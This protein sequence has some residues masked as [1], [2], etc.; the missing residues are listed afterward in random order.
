MRQIETNGKWLSIF[1]SLGIPVDGHG[2]HEICPL[3]KRK[4][5]RYDD[6]EGEGTWIC[7]CDAGSS[8]GW[9]LIIKYFEL[10]EGREG[11][12]AALKMVSEAESKSGGFTKKPP[13]EKKLATPADLNR[14]FAEANKQREGDVVDLYLFNRGIEKRP[15][16]NLWHS[17]ECWNSDT[18]RKEHAMMSVWTMPD[19][20]A[21][22]AERTYLTADGN[23]LDTVP[24]KLVKKMTSSLIHN[25]TGG[26]VRLFDLGESKTLGLAEGIETTLAATQHFNIPFWATWTADRL[27]GWMPPESVVRQVDHLVVVGDEDHSF[28]GQAKAY[29]LCH[30]LYCMAK[31]LDWDVKITPFFPDKVGCDWVDVINGECSCRLRG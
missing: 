4:G 22:Q 3:C 27:M 25:T 8:N 13:G 24:P 14:M 20:R 18:K 31:R 11:F 28:A 7:K 16:D 15:D 26:C 30:R 2:K 10:G 29:F 5:F 21:V 19:G 6:L 23:K 17:P 1:H 9:G 12:I